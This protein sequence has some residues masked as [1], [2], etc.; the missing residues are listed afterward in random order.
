M[1]NYGNAYGNKYFIT[2]YC[3]YENRMLNTNNTVVDYNK[4]KND[5]DNILKKPLVDINKY[6]KEKQLEEKKDNID[7]DINNV[8]IN[9]IDEIIR[10]TYV[11]WD[12]ISQIQYCDRDEGH[13]DSNYITF[14]KDARKFL[15][16]K[17]NDILIPILK[18]KIQTVS[19]FE[20][21]DNIQIKNFMTHIIFKGPE[22]YKAVILDPDLSLYL[23]N[24][25]YPIYD[26]LNIS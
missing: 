1:N 3:D 9:N 7:I 19:S 13:V 14:N 26:W 21:L 2:H 23:Y 17:L 24:N 6:K 25:Y 4:I 15:L 11:F 12:I 16:S 18:K 5:I 22:F 10:N 20:N 8:N